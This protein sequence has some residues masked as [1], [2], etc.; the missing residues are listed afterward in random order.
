MSIYVKH[1]RA[2]RMESFNIRRIK[3]I[4]V[5]GT[6]ILELFAGYFASIRFRNSF[7]AFFVLGLWQS[8]CCST[9]LRIFFLFFA[10]S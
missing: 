6:F 7:A 10:C 1:V 9:N 8:N 4:K 3:G 2:L 5:S